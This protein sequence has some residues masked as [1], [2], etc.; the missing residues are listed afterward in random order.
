M[1]VVA[2]ILKWPK[3]TL[4]SSFG[5]AVLVASVAAWITSGNGRVDKNH[6]TYAVMEELI[7]SPR[8]KI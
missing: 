2:K 3:L 8:H 4:F 6:G 1:P 5:A 7:N